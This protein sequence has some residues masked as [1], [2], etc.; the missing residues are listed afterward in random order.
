MTIFNYSKKKSKNFFY[1][2]RSYCSDYEKFKKNR[3]NVNLNCFKG[4]KHFFME[5]FLMINQFFR[6][7]FSRCA[8]KAYYKNIQII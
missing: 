1:N 7:I 4:L 5:N 3:R 2:F 6:V 8:K